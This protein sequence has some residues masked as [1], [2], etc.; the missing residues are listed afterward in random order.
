MG[1]TTYA[2]YNTNFVTHTQKRSIERVIHRTP[3]KKQ[4]KMACDVPHLGQF[5]PIQVCVNIT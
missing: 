1:S 4:V 3:E 2:P 5:I